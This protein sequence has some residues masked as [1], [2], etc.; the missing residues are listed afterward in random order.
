MTE[1]RF[2]LRTLSASALAMGICL[3]GCGGG[4]P[5]YVQFANG[6]DFAVKAEVTAEGGAVSTV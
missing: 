5:P 6:F 3:V 1:P 2:S 4:G